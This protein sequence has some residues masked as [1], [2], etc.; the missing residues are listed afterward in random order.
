MRLGWSSTFDKREGCLAQSQRYEGCDGLDREVLYPLFSTR[1]TTASTI[2]LWRATD[3]TSAA[4]TISTRSSRGRNA[5]L[6]GASRS[7]LDGTSAMPCPQP[8]KAICDVTER[9]SCRMRGEKPCALQ[10]ASTWSK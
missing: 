1:E 9:T 10:A 5:T 2:G 8:T 7:N 6:G 3:H 4:A